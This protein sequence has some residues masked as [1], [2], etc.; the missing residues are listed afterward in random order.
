MSWDAA[1]DFCWRDNRG[2][3]SISDESENSM[4]HN[5]I[6]DLDMPIWIGLDENISSWT[7]SLKEPLSQFDQQWEDN[8]LDNVTSLD[9]C[10]S[11]TNS[12]FWRGRNC[13]SVM[14][15]FC[16]DGKKCRTMFC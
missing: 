12:C 16:N 10:A 6:K 15:F 7:W 8:E 11:I 9:N 1:Q 14:P 5:M 2:L 13:M 3:A 4:I